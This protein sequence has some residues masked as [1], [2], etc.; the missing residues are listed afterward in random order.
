V[1]AEAV[2]G[3]WCFACQ[4]GGRIYDL[5]SLLAGGT[6]GWFFWSVLF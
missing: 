4:R 2:Q 1:Y 6:W 5:A 3:C